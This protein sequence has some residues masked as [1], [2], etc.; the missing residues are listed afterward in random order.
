MKA[1]YAQLGSLKRATLDNLNVAMDGSNPTAVL[2]WT[3]T[4][5]AGR[6]GQIIDRMGPLVRVVGVGGPRTAEVDAL[7]RRLGCVHEDDL[8]KL[9]VDR[10]ADVL[11]LGAAA[12]VAVQ[13]V[14]AA[15]AG[16]M[17]VVAIEPEADNFT[18]LYVIRPTGATTEQADRVI[19]AAAFER[20][21][22]WTSAADPMQVVGAPQLI[23]F[24]SFGHVDDCSLLSRLL[25]AWRFILSLTD[26][27][28]SID[29]SLSGP[30]GAVP[31]ELRGLTGH[32]AAHARLPDG[33]S[34]VL[35]IS[36]RA[37]EHRR[38][39]MLVGKGGVLRVEDTDYTL[40]DTTG[41]L[42]DQSPPL[43]GRTAFVDLIADDW[44]QVMRAPAGEPQNP[45]KQL[46]RERDALA[47]CLATMLSARTQEPENPARL[48]ELQLPG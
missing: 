3:D 11:L 35:Q 47:C 6:D 27:P 18:D 4:A 1:L 28:H 45:A 40:R 32:I 33:G 34:V 41:G 9:L 22:G 31:Q 7:A 26:M 30:L 43:R 12:D 48:A 23:S 24:T 46:V 5:C 36:D 16:G 44:R 29:A 8:R 14:A 38:H 10:P 39:L 37:G 42:V 13:D 25:D 2:I 21:R 19:A 20:S 15:V 17:M